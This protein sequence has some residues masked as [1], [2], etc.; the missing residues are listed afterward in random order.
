MATHISSSQVTTATSQVH[1]RN[2]GEVSILQ[3]LT[4][5]LIEWQERYHQRYELSL[6]DDRML[7][8][9]GLTRSD[10]EVETSKLFWQ[11]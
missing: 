5:K 7:Q 9:I 3:R 1:G 2:T 4:E 8:D 10:V 6:L 11:A